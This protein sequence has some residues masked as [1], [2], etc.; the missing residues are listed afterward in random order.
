MK[1]F[2]QIVISVALVYQQDPLIQNH[3]PVVLQC[4][5]VTMKAIKCCPDKSSCCCIKAKANC[6]C[7]KKPENSDSG[8][9]IVFVPPYSESF[10]Y[11]VVVTSL[12]S[13]VDTHNNSKT[14]LNKDCPPLNFILSSLNTPLLA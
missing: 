12:S 10:Q 2:I 3:I 11:D 5:Q 8:L 7:I 14:Y 13:I 4:A 1:F 9:P 6:C